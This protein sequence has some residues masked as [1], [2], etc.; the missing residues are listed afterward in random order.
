M[1][2]LILLAM[3]S[4]SCIATGRLKCLNA[5]GTPLDLVR[6]VRTIRH[7]AGMRYKVKALVGFYQ[8][9]AA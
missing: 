1:L 6:Y 5:C 9:I 3:L 2:L 4:G 7:N 8:C